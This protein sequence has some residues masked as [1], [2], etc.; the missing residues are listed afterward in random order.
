M[1]TVVGDLW[2]IRMW[3]VVTTNLTVRA[4][5]CAVMGRGVAAQ[6]VEKWPD[7]PRWLGGKIR[8]GQR[9][10]V[11]HEEHALLFLP[12]KVHWRDRADVHLLER[13]LSELAAFAAA[14][15]GDVIVSPVPGIGFGG[16]DRGAVDDL[17]R[18]HLGDNVVLVERGGEVLER[19][20]DSLRASVLPDRSLHR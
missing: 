11:V 8:A 2:A 19:Y 1:R 18:R 6:A 20:A 12:V 13:S 10:L 7:I 14:H 5:G 9:G 16:L 17:L 4:D 3:R 15:P